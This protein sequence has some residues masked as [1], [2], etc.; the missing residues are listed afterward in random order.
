MTFGLEMR[1]EGTYLYVCATG[2]RTTDN[3]AAAAQQIITACVEH[4]LDAALVDIREFEG[5]ISVVDSFM[6]PVSLF[7]SLKQLGTLNRVAIL[8]TKER[9]ER[10]RFFETVA[11]KGGYNVRAFSRL[12][13]AI[14]WLTAEAEAESES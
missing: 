6:I 7:P 2:E 8:D 3:I 12:Q 4:R 11:R 14:D 1:P 13:C 10:A 9:G 5:R